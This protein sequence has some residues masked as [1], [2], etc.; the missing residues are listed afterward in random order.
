MGG[1]A[2][3]Y[4]DA[5][6]FGETC[7]A[8]RCAYCA[9]RAE[10]KNGSSAWCTYK[11]VAPDQC[12]GGSRPGIVYSCTQQQRYCVGCNKRSAFM[13]RTLCVNIIGHDH[14][15]IAAI[16]ERGCACRRNVLRLLRPTR[17][18]RRFW[19]RMIRN[20]TDD[21]TSSIVTSIPQRI[22]HVK[23][24]PLGAPTLGRVDGF[25]Q[26]E[27]RGEVDEGQE[28]YCGLLAA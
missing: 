7:G 17:W 24:R 8:M 11:R 10:F 16:L 25:D 6:E 13:G 14:G 21:A 18:Q 19:E 2:S 20:E 5:R 27:A 12:T 28:V 15:W 4:D 26:N 22:R 23:M 3:P 9:L 1:G